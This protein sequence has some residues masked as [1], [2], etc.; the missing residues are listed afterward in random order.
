M[1]HYAAAILILLMLS[2]VQPSTARPVRAVAA[3]DIACDPAHHAFGG[4]DD[5]RAR[6]HS[7]QTAR[8]IAALHPD[9]VLPLGDL[10]YFEE[11]VQ[12]FRTGYGSTWGSF[13]AISYPA[14]GNHEYEIPDAAGYFDYWGARAGPRGEGWYSW[15]R[16]GWHFIAL[17]GNCEPSGGCS[18]R[19][20]QYQ[21]L[22]AD[23][24]AHRGVCTL[25][26]WH[27]PRFSSGPHGND[28]DYAGFWRALYRA[29]ADIVLNGHDHDYERFVPM[30]PQEETDARGLREFV[31]GTGGRN[32]SQFF[33][34]P[35]LQS[36]ARQNTEFGVLLLELSP[37]TYRWRFI[38]ESGGTFRDAGQGKCHAYTKD[39]R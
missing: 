14:V 39:A 24:L 25:A 13:K 26:Y 21:W 11:D 8:L 33:F 20:A 32:H 35:H 34:P 4:K 38:P 12:A 1:K 17:N 16:G 37:N 19:S 31:V 29:G 30:N 7:A 18:E 5:S 6:C 10:Q 22:A 23:L 27:Q 36:A 3:G 28:S 15:D 9:L 2:A